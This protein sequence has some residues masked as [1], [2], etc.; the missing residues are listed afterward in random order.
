M[1]KTIVNN[2]VYIEKQVRTPSY[3]MGYEHCH[4]YYEIF[5]LK[6]GAC[7]FTVNKQRYQVEAGDI[8]IVAP[9]DSHSTVY[10]GEAPCERIIVCCWLDKLA[11]TF[12][13]DH[14]D[15]YAKFQRS[16]RVLLDTYGQKQ[17]D[18]IID[19]MLQEHRVTMPY[20]KEMMTLMLQQ[21][22]LCIDRCSRFIYDG[23]SSPYNPT[24]DIDNALKYINLHYQHSITLS[25]V[26]K[27]CNL[28]PTYLSRKFRN[29]TGDTFK[30]YLTKI[31]L[32]QARQA[33][34]TTDDTITKIA[35]DCG[36]ESSNYFKD[37]FRKNVGLSPRD[38]R[39]ASALRDFEAS[40]RKE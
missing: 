26:A 40:Q 25:E 7:I 14:N 10:V 17:A 13:T 24:S 29:V 11:P 34:I 35:M 31:R 32:Q 22:L 5:Y 12:W 4:S 19:E 6:S 36:F 27:I 2:Y 3:A 30:Q 28:T 16:G 20:S 23:I 33:L 21:L 39:K 38:F 37:T 8:F 15:L 18:I 9:G 1:S